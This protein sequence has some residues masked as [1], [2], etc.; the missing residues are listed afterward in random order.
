MPGA[1]GT[2][3]AL[4]DNVNAMA[5]SL[6]VQVRAIADVATAVTRGDL[7]RQIAVEA[8]G[9]LDQLKNN[10]NQMIVNLKSTT[11]KNSEQDWLKTNLAKF[12][13]MMQGQKDLEAVSKLIMS[14]L[15][16]LVSAHHGAFY[17][18]DDD[19]HTPVLKL[20]ASYAY[21]ER[22]HVGN[23]FH[24]GEG[25][26]GP[27]GAREEADSA[28]RTFRTTTSASPRAWARR[29]LATCSCFRFCS[30]AK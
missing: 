26:V 2:W 8:Q 11:E 7:S 12:S 17:I 4:T 22:K 5:N 29:H 24:L 28:H 23:R 15:T 27:G 3:R 6:T 30:R 21:K 1:A 10:M 16:P 20:I 18:M 14:E 9:E 13:R 25:L 19:D